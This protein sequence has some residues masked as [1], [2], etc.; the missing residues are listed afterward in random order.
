MS[1]LHSSEAT[2]VNISMYFLSI[3][4][5]CVCVCLH[6]RGKPTIFIEHYLCSEPFVSV[7]NNLNNKDE[8]T[9]LSLL[10]TTQQAFLQHEIRLHSPCYYCHVLE[11]TF[12]LF[13]IPIHCLSLSEKK[14]PWQPS[15]VHQSNS[16]NRIQ[17]VKTRESECV[18]GFLP[19][20]RRKCRV[21]T[22]VSCLD[23]L[24]LFGRTQTPGASGIVYISSNS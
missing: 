3:S 2:I 17:S 19:L 12:V 11:C 23:M 20:S 7:L 9:W 4:F 14:S 10:W 21:N 6:S 13:V 15:Q 1:K 18:R 16:G 22:V 24:G 8:G 5:V